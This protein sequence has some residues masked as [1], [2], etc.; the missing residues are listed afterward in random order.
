MFWLVH[1]ILAAIVAKSSTPEWLLPGMAVLIRPQR[2]YAI[3]G[4]WH[5][6]Q[7]VHSRAHQGTAISGSQ[8][9]RR[10]CGSAGSKIFF[11]KYNLIWKC[12]DRRPKNMYWPMC[13]GN[14]D[15]KARLKKKN[16]VGILETYSEQN[17]NVF[18]SVVLLIF[19]EWSVWRILWYELHS[20][21]TS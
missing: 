2:L 19:K 13:T 9:N 7:A 5:I 21:T 14:E 6:S 8:G 10:Q 15:N 20:H 18:L 12:S 3:S 17:W 11:K 16:Q 1:H 4:N